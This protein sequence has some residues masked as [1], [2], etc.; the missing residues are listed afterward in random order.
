MCKDECEICKRFL[1]GKMDISE[2]RW[3]FIKDHSTESFSSALVNAI[4]EL[5]YKHN[6]RGKSEDKELEKTA[7]SAR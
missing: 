2:F 3:H 1:E 6:K 4:K 5:W 7:S